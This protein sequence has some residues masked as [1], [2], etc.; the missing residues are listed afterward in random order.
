[1]KIA[2]ILNA[3]IAFAGLYIAILSVQGYA[4]A[5]SS[6]SSLRETAGR[7]SDMGILLREREIQTKNTWKRCLYGSAVVVTLALIVNC[8]LVGSSNNNP[9]IYK[10]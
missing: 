9:K 5:V 2:R 8:L 4:E 10:K 3:F 7:N 1:M 6:G